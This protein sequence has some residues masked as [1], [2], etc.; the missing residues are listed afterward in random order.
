MITK[1]GDYLRK[2]RIRNQQILKNMADELGV[3]SA[4]LSAVENGKKNMPESWYAILHEH[5][6][7]DDAEM[8]ELRQA[9]ME[10]QKTISLNLNNASETNR[11]LAVSFA[12]QFDSIDE[13]F[14]KQLLQILR[15]RKERG[16]GGGPND[17]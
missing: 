9:A 3:S 10:S 16:D 2:L 5:Y 6:S 11:Q 15:K 17:V 12:R 1:L 13:I 14:G 7:L 4:F 8:E